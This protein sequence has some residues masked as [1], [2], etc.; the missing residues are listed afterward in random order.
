[1]FNFIFSESPLLLLSSIFLIILGKIF[2]LYLMT[3]AI[4]I[5]IFLLFFYRKPILTYEPDE[6]YLLS[7]GFGTV[8]RILYIENNRV[9]VTIFLNPFNIHS[10]Y[11]PCNGTVLEQIYD[12]TGKYEIASDAYKSDEN[13]KLI[14]IMNSDIDNIK[15]TQLAGILV[16]RISTPNN[17]GKVVKQGDYLG[18]IKFGSRVDI[19]F[20]LE[21]YEL[22]SDYVYQGS[23]LNGPNSKIAIKKSKSSRN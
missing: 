17:I 16:R 12:N 8:S 21:K 5:L 6:N 10:Q 1:M 19:E 9:L 20:S 11:F 13:E 14:T 2:N 23:I 7:P 3:I 4:I 18:F 22:L 15:I